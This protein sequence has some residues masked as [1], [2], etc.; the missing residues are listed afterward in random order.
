M[1]RRQPWVFLAPPASQYL[2]LPV[3]GIACATAFSFCMATGAV[4]AQEAPA[5]SSQTQAPPETATQTP[6][7][8][9]AKTSPAASKKAK[10]PVNDLS[11]IQVTGISSGIQSALKVKEKLR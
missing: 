3:L 6:A 9:G 5:Q 1:S 4:L 7:T 10:P 11:V 8:T 2:Y